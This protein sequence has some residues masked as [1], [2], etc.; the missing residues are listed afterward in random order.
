MTKLRAWIP[1]AALLCLAACS[2]KPAEQDES[3]AVTPVQVANATTSTIHRRITAEAVLYPLKQA[4]IV[5]KI[6]APV[7]RFYAQRGDHV[8]EGQLLA[9]LEARDLRATAEESKELYEQAQANFTSTSRATVPEDVAKSKADLE[10]SRQALDAARHVYESRL[11]LYHEGA[12]ARKLVDDAEVSLAQA[13]SQ[14]DTAQAHLKGLEN[15][16]TTQ[17]VRG[18][19][20]QMDAAKAHYESA[21]AQL[22]YTEVRSPL[23]GVISDRPVNLGDMASAGAALFTVVDI[24]QV[25]A[26]ANIPVQDASMIR[27]GQLATISGPAGELAGKISVVSPAV[28]ANTTTLQVWVDAPNPGERFKPGATVQISID[29]GEVKNAVVVPVAALLPSDQGGEQVMIASTDGL[30][31]AREV[32]TGVR[33]GNQVQILSGVKPGEQVITQGALGLDDK[34][35]IQI[36]KPGQSGEGSDEEGKK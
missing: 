18:A 32:Q 14:F 34:A 31:H 4:N 3:Q 24:S 25:V 11:K 12:L 21:E 26:R 36:T 17:Q 28:D 2:Q 35:K 1:L 6:S 30:A 16:G 15:F 23:T 22:S 20:A 5:P 27:S 13:Q 8:R 10:A 7:Q 33:E 19:Q 9:V 29:L